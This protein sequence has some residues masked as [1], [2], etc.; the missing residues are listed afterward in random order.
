[1]K[2]TSMKR[3]FV[4][5][6]HGFTAILA[7]IAN[8]FTTILG[9]KDDSKY[10]KFIR[11]VVGSSFAVIMVML[12]A[13]V[14]YS[15][16]HAFYEELPWK[17]RAKECVYDT[18]KLSRGVTYFHLYD[19]PGYVKNADGNKT[20]TDIDWLFKPLGRDTLACYK[21]GDKRG[22][23]SLLTG[24][25]AIKP[26][27]A[28]AWIFSDGLACVDDN[29]WLKFI[30]AKGKVAIDLKTPYNPE[31][32][33]YVFHNNHCVIANSDLN[34]V[35]LIDKQGNWVLTAKYDA[36]EPVD[37]FWIV[38]QGKKQ[39]VLNA[40]MGTVF[41]FAEAKY[42]IL[43]EMITEITPD[44][45]IRRYTLQGKLINDFYIYNVEQLTYETNELR[46]ESTK[47]YD[48]E[49]NVTSE[50]MNSVPSPIHAVARCK[51][52]ETEYDWYGLMS[53]EGKIITPP[54]Y[55]SIKAIA[56]DLYLCEDSECRGVILNGKGQKVR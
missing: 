9:M 29:G 17:C 44:H 22:Y 14:V 2:S 6:W 43:D 26:Q 36:I 28:H 24:E 39:S 38:T 56:Y 46:Y 10:G 32:D 13:A 30:D 49:G 23:L 1:M 27:Y 7:C 3:A 55:S 15:V 33:G 35:G 54:I 45:I 8:W 41:P 5:F 19:N 47:N 48:D 34:T 16:C 50:E 37:T 18:M 53:P 42:S 25:V 21:S 31:Y 20:V 40:S 11:R 52:Y 12:T 4:L 51:Q